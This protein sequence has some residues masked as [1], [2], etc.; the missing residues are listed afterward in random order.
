MTDDDGYPI[1]TGE[2]KVSRGH[3]HSE[4]TGPGDNRFY[5]YRVNRDKYNGFE[6]ISH[7]YETREQAEKV[8]AV[9]NKPL[10]NN[11][12]TWRVIR[13]NPNGGPPDDRYYVFRVG[14]TDVHPHTYLTRGVAEAVA[15][16]LNSTGAGQ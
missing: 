10:V 11:I 15:R 7:S 4:H 1:V 9:A 2:W 6:V 14:C 16:T 8:A 12:G 13:G 5:V 3:P